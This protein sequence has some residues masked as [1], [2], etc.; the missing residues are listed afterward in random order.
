MNNRN[1]VIYS[2]AAVIAK[3]TYDHKI[4]VIVHEINYIRTIIIYSFNI[5]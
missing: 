1:L 4:L 2:V 5:I 3:N